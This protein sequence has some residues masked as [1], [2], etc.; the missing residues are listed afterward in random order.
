MLSDFISLI[1]PQNCSGCSSLL[2][3]SEKGIC[4]SCFIELDRFRCKTPINKFIFGRKQ[5]SGFIPVFHLI[6]GGALHNMLHNIKYSNNRISANILGIEL[7][8]RLKQC[9][10]KEKI[11]CIVPVPISKKKLKLRKFNQSEE[12]AKGINKVLDIP[13]EANWLLRKNS[14]K[15]QTFSNRFER[16]KNVKEEYYLNKKKTL[17]QKRL[18]IL[19]DVVTTGATI[20]SCLE[21]ISKEENILVY[22]ASV[23]LTKKD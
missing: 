20:D 1:Y 17:S 16:S 8:K 5:V 7:G 12:I 22:V 2:I 21:A 11:D 4:S 23:A 18:L 6:K 19:D 15:S 3:H 10:I 13:I 14:L 9:N